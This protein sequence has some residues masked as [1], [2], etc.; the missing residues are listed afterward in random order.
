MP[1]TTRESEFTVL[2]STISTRGTARPAI[3]VASVLGWSVGAM[4]LLL[5][6]DVPL[7]SA[8][9]LL[10]LAAG[11]EAVHGLHVGV[12]R[13]GRYLLVEYESDEPGPRWETSATAFGPSL[14]GGAVD[15]L[16]AVCFISCA[17]LNLMMVWVLESTAMEFL[18]LASLHAAFVV[19]V[20]RS[21]VAAGR[22][23]RVEAERL[24]AARA[25][26]S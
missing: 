17:L 1:V 25:A 12:E 18:V 15:P 16:F 23:R 26:R 4:V 7:A 8:I 9:P 24:V 19:R 14:P 3:F 2:R 10:V 21:R 5:F 6:G 11:F 13:I 22:Q 20:T